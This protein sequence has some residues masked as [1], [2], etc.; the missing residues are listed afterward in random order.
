MKP[1][2]NNASIDIEFGGETLTLL[3]QKAVVWGRE[4]TLFIADVHLG[5]A[6]SFRAAGLAVPSGHSQDDVAQIE[7]LVVAHEISHLVVLGDLVHN[8]ASYTPTLDAAMRHFVSQHPTLKRTLVIGNHDNSA[9]LPPLEWSFEC[10]SEFLRLAP[11]N[12]LHEPLNWAKSNR[13]ASNVDRSTEQASFS[14]AGHIHPAA[15]LRTPREAV[16]L[17]CFWQSKTQLV[18]PS[19][20]RLTGRFIVEPRADDVTYVVTGQQIFRNPNGYS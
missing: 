4:R 20:G 7:R 16:N 11:F 14:L 18:L 15:W 6:A 19:F 2:S 5:K 1:R 17:P 10:I 9:G 8:R 13:V 3:A 12:C